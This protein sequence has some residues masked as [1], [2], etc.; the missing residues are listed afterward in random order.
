[1][2]VEEKLIAALRQRGPTLLSDLVTLG[3]M[4]SE[5]ALLKVA[6]ASEGRIVQDGGQLLLPGQEDT[7]PGSD[8]DGRL[9]EYV[10]FDLETTS[11]NPEQAEIIE[12]AAVRVRDGQEVDTFQRLVYGPKLSAEITNLTSIT[13]QMLMDEGQPL[14]AVLNDFLIWAGSLPL[15][16]HNALKYDLPVLRRAL[17]TV[18]REW[19]PRPV[20]DSLLLAPLAF[21]RDTDLPEV[22]SLGALHARLTGDAHAQAHRALDDCRATLKV[23]QACLSRLDA[24]PDGV[25]AVLMG[26]PV[27]EFQLL[28]PPQEAAAEGFKTALDALLRTEARRTHV[29]RQNG[30]TARRPGELL[31]SPR[32][33]QE[34]MLAEVTQTLGN[35]GV[36]VIEAPTGTGKTRGYLFPALLQGKSGQPVIIS[37]H[38]RQLQNQILDE[39]RAAVD[40]GFNLNVLALKGQGNYLCPA[41]FSDWLMSKHDPEQGRLFLSAGEARAAALLLLYADVGEFADLPPAPIRFTAD[42]HRLTQTVATQRARCGDACPFHTHCA[43][44]PLFQARTQASVVVVNH[45]LLFQTLLQGKDDLAGLPLKRVIV[46]EAHDLSEAAYAAL[47]R[48]VSVQ[49]LRALANELLELRPRRLGEQAHGRGQELL[50]LLDK[51]TA[52]LPGLA[53]LI[54]QLRVLLE[55]APQQPHRLIAPTEA[56]L[57]KQPLMP[58]ELIT[59][60]LRW[61][62][63]T[64]AVQGFLSGATLQA[65]K[66]GDTEMVVAILRL[67]PRLDDLQDRLTLWHEKLRPFAMQ[68]GEGGGGFGYTVAVTLQ[69]R[70][71]HE[72]RSVRDAGKNLLP[73]LAGLARHVQDLA[74]YPAIKD[75]ATLL[76]QR[77]DA[78]HDALQGLLERDPGEDVYAVSASEDNG[79]LWSVPLWLH[80]RLAPLWASLESVTLTSATLRIP[81]SDPAN[82]E[83]D[84]QDF[85]LF[86]EELGLPIARFMALPPVLPYHKGRVLLTTHLPLTRQPGFALMAGQ[87]LAALAPQLPHRQLHILTA[88]ERQ[89]GV[90]KQLDRQ[91]VPHLSSVTDGADRTVRELGRR[92]TAVALGSAGFMQGVDIRD[93]SVVS[94]DRLPFPIPDVVLSQQRV[95]LGDFEQFWNRVYLP[96]A[97]LKFVQ[98]F[99]RLV[100]DDRETVGDGAF[101]LWDKRLPVSHYQARFLGALPVPPQ[102]IVRLPDRQAMYRALEQVFGHPLEMP[103]LL[104]PKQQRIAELAAA[105]QNSDPADWPPLLEEGLRD[106]FELPGATLREGQWDG[107]QAALSGRDVL[108]VLPTGSGKSVIFQ[109]PALLTPGYTLVIS[110]LVALMQD[111]V[112]RLQQLGLPAAGLWGGLSR[113]EQL[114]SLNDT[115]RGDVKLLYVA[116]ERVRRS[117]DLQELL[118][119]TP[120]AR[121]V[122]DE[123]HCLTEW[124][125]DFR[126]D[127]LKVSA[128]LKTWGLTPPVSAFTATATPAVQSQLKT[129]LGLRDPAHTVQPVARPNLHYLV[130]TTTKGQRDQAL[131]DLILGLQRTELGKAGRVIVYCGSRDGTER[132]AALLRELHVKAE[133]YHAGLSTAIRAELVELFQDREVAVMVATNAFGMGVDAPDIRLVVHYDP[134]L[135]LEAYVQE[136]GRAGRDGQP[137]HAVMLKSG[138]LRKRATTLISRSYPS[139]KEAEELLKNISRATYPTE[140][141]LSDENIDIS[142]L[143]TVLHLLDEAGVVAYEY[144]PGPYRVFA[145]YGVQPPK[146]PQ[147][148]ELLEESAPVNLTRRYGK[149]EAQVLQDKLHRYAREGVLGVT[150]LAPALDVHVKRWD[151]TPYEAKRKLLIASKLERFGHFEAF[152]AAQ[153]CREYQ[154]HGYFDPKPHRRFRC[155]RCDICTPEAPKPWSG[156]AQDLSSIWNPERE[157]LRLMH[158][159]RDRPRGKGTLIRLLMGEDGSMRG[160]TFRSYSTLE[161]SSPGYGLLKHLDKTKIEQALEKLERLQCVQSTTTDTYTVLALT[162]KGQ[163]EAAKWIRL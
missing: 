160:D 32:P 147:I 92:P 7:E 158:Y 65:Q 52:Q 144:V 91:Q 82:G 102:N 58:R 38:T 120:P 100:R 60:Y 28:W 139:G 68:Y 79:S 157:V 104:A 151:L 42:Y 137:A 105:I 124:G 16:G 84:I 103:D 27:P 63:R 31:T 130:Q 73:L 56:W 135:S 78:A 107:M 71:S 9:S 35:G 96:R 149:A 48:E 89:Q 112:L 36:S 126:P 54:G 122:Y 62:E 46:D 155:E 87:E 121:V 14:D 83:G 156:F 75:E 152:L 12:L 66:R 33:G 3:I 77:L 64:A 19:T 136:A 85:G 24:F 114:G 34:R 134:P 113:G 67:T 6:G 25:K 117:K 17:A 99:G 118:Q 44:Y 26:L 57:S 86:Q 22:Y 131:V 123:A 47:R 116:P 55:A 30:M 72:F 88:R 70:E 128:Q 45:A 111:Q 110:P 138:N 39:A 143:P 10:V 4:S 159:F 93:L 40:A 161:K 106:L 20:L 69:L 141:E 132:V 11:A 5:R 145:L 37:T 125:H 29:Q 1:M 98:A 50:K 148:Q 59:P 8:L 140:R 146:D 119:R 23:V 74:R 13:P 162:D 101:I 127:Y 163:Q 90:S 51:H 18:N 153:H 94:L 129:L 43:F 97:V 142:R 133:A 80:A 76:K 21:A 154:L 53:G 2:S 61:R 81:G 41:R 115:E 109:L 150:P 95:A 15:L 108:T 49:N